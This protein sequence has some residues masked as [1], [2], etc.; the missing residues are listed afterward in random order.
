MNQ[1]EAEQRIINAIKQIKG[2]NISI[3]SDSRLF[4]DLG[5]DSLAFMEFVVYLE[6]EFG[7]DLEKL[8]VMVDDLSVYSLA[9]FIIQP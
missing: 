8:V 7:V 4:G 2:S 5:F 6:S 1:Y 9:G 3:N